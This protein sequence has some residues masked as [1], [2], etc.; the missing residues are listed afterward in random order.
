MIR[1]KPL[2]YEKPCA[3]VPV[4][5]ADYSNAFSPL[6]TKRH[7]EST[8]MFLPDDKKIK[9]H[10]TAHHGGAHELLSSYRLYG[11]GPCSCAELS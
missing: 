1:P 8:T 9:A 4:K 11:S 6:S 10:A 2:A 3:K 5:R 7:H